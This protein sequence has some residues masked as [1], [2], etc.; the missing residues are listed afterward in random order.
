MMPYN[1]II[2]CRVYNPMGFSKKKLTAMDCA[3]RGCR[4]LGGGGVNILD[5]GRNILL[6]VKALLVYNSVFDFKK[7]YNPIGVLHTP[8]YTVMLMT[9]QR[10]SGRLGNGRLISADFF[11]LCGCAVQKAFCDYCNICV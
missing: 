3:L 4:L 5:F 8:D 11:L 1:D 6:C 9:F 7:S 10:K 2:I